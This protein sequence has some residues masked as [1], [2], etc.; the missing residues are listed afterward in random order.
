LATEAD[1]IRFCK[2]DATNT[3]VVLKS[4]LLNAGKKKKR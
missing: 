1:A 2:A 3:I 4:A